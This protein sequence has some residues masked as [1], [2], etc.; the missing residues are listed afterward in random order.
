MN[1]KKKPQPQPKPEPKDW[2]YEPFEDF[3]KKI[4]PAYR[5]K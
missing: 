5:K 2:R 4:D 1:Q 3:V